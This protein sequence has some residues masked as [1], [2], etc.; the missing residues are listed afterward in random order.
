MKPQE[1]SLLL[2]IW[3]LT[4]N[5]FALGQPPHT[6]TQYTSES[7]LT[8]KMIPCMLQDHKGIMWFAT[9]DGLYKFDG[10]TFKNYKARPGDNTELDN[11]RLDY[12]KEDCYGF[13]WIQSYGGKIYRFCPQTEQF[14]PILQPN[15]TPRNIYVLPTGTVWITTN[16]NELFYLTTHPAS[17]E[18]TINNFFQSQETSSLAKV[19]HVYSDRN[20]N[21]WILTDKGLY[22][23]KQEALG[24]QTESFFTH[25]AT[26]GWHSFYDATEDENSLYFSSKQGRFI[27][28]TTGGK[29]TVDSLPTHSALKIIRYLPPDKLFIGTANDGF[30][31]FNTATKAYKHYSKC[32]HRGLKNN[33][34]KDVYIDSHQD[35]WIRTGLPGIVR[36]TPSSGRIDHFILQDKHGHDITESRV[37]MYVFEDTNGSTWVHPSGGGFAWFN[38]EE[39]RLVPFYNPALQ[40]GWNAENRVTSAFADKQGN[41]WLCTTENGLAKITFNN[42][43]FHLLPIRPNDI[44]HTSNSVR[45]V[46]QDN[47]G[48]IWI[49]SKDRIIRL[50]DKDLCYLGNLTSQGAVIPHAT[51]KLGM[52]YAFAQDSQGN[53]W[54]GTKGNGLISARRRHTGLTYQLYHY[55]AD[56]RSPYSLSGNDIYSLH[57]D[58]HQRLWIATFEAGINYL[59]LKNADVSAR[60]INHKNELTH[61]PIDQCYRTRFITESP[62]GDIWIGSVAGLLLCA[63]SNDKPEQMKFRR[64]TRIPEDEHSLSNNDV[65]N[66]FFA[67]NNEMYI[68]TF[69]GGFN[70]LLSIDQGEARFQA[71]TTLKGLPSDVVLS[72]QEDSEGNIWFTTE[73]DLCKFLPDTEEITTYQTKSFPVH[74]KFDEGAA[75]R[76]QDNQ[77]VFNTRKGIFHF[78]PDS[79]KDS[80]YTPSIIFTRFQQPEDKSDQ[81]SFN[82]IDDATVILLPHNQ[83]S[84]SIEFAALDMK[85]P[86][87]ISYAYQL[88][89]FEKSW[90][91]IGKQR[92]ATYT[93]LP[94]GNYTFK[95]KSTNSDGVWTGNIR[96]LSITVLPSFWETPWAYL[97]YTM[98]TIG[99][100]WGTSYTLFIIFRLKHKVTIEQEISDIKLRF[101]TNISHE[102]RTPLTLIAGPIEHIL[103][104]GNMSDVEREQLTLVERNTQR[105][106]HLVNQILDF[107][108]IQNKKMKMRVQQIDLIPFTRRIMED[109]NG[110][111]DEHQIDFSLTCRLQSLMIWADADKLEKILFNLISNAFKYTPQGKSIKVRIEEHDVDAVISIEDQGIGIADSKLQTVF[112]RFENLL[113]QPPFNQ[114][115]TGIGLSLVKELVNL[116]HGK[117]D[118]QS[119]VGEGSTF[120]VRLLKSKNHFDSATEF[121][122]SDQAKT[123]LSHINTPL[124]YI[125][126]ITDDNT[127][128][129]KETLLIVEDNNEL[130][131]FLRTVFWQYFNIV[132]AENGAEA[133]EKSKKLQPDIIVSDV[134]M[135]LKD[136]IEMTRELREDINTSHIPI[137]LL[138]AKTTTES[139]LAGMKYG[140]DAYITKPF[141]TTLLKARVFN[142]LEQR[143]KLQVLYCA[144]LKPSL[145]A[146]SED[147]EKL[148][149]APTLPPN[150]QNFMDTLLAFINAHLDNGDIRVEDMAKE[151][152]MS[153]TVFFKKLKTLTGLSPVEFLRDMRIKNAAELIKQNKYNMAQIAYMVGFNDSHYFSRCFKA[154]YGMT[155]S[156]YKESH[157]N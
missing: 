76:T 140:A 33:H 130:R 105:M 7:G 153:R 69:G 51:D 96:T 14:Q 1:K 135:P 93:N 94:K 150:D 149:D 132:E 82:N 57:V 87:S 112:E 86:N 124:P 13:I 67:K 104:N 154:Q 78:L 99:L 35:V 10:Y 55:E 144:S 61:Y 5:C 106:L 148:P 109:F 3:I 49:G 8:Q 134:M 122:L 62:Q 155:P 44:E 50:Y 12:I 68:A 114:S 126:E 92:T 121:I 46:F 9:W 45:A 90:N 31:L 16:Q 11:N 30:F 56:A 47:E 6:F 136:G 27:Q 102:L 77:L 63:N 117:I 115:S 107:R 137:I 21:Q 60:F 147:S 23:A 32:T 119:K 75:L 84:F 116:H 66:I 36:F 73:E 142:L 80:D 139:R 83:N 34:I 138:T 42:S 48:N 25:P 118:V 52:A 2:L 103:H 74:V 72:I 111:A 64:F 108:K 145:Q 123:D 40:N 38:R 88:E 29:T 28:I 141:S 18:L 41:L 26:R 125:N 128:P 129:E 95:V 53:V 15:D 65:H 131:F 110:M 152:N 17:H 19:N 97:L 151:V 58:S 146:D 43:H 100:I 113:D 91:Y 39:N 79:I 127:N 81:R 20:R 71:Y 4:M 37:E 133:L 120:I 98:G 24:M 157:T 85:F 22:K 70:K 59:D 54:I 89:G 156:E 143:K 101:F